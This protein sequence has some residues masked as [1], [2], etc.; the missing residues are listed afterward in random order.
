V[1]QAGKVCLQVLILRIAAG[2]EICIKYCINTQ[3]L[4]EFP[5]VRIEKDY[6]LRLRLLLC[7]G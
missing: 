6:P 5:K 1:P 2:Q 3:F 7:I 4:K